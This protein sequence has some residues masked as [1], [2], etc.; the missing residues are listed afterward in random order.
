MEV[1]ESTIDIAASPQT[2]WS[3]IDDIDRYPEWNP[4]VPRIAGRTT[5]GE[6][7]SG[8]LVIPDMPTP[9]LTPMI[10]RIVAGRE[11]RWKSVI[12]GAQGFS[13]EH[14]FILEP[15]GEGT[16]LI[17]REVFDGPAAS[18]LA[19]PIRLFVAPAYRNFDVQLKARAEE[20]AHASPALHPSVAAP[21]AETASH[22]TLRCLC[23]S[24]QVEVTLKEAVQHNHLCGCSK[25]W[26]PQGALL[27]QTAVVAADAAYISAHGEK[28]RLV[29]AASAI[30][31]HSCRDCGT[32]LIGTVEDPTHHFYGLAFVHPELSA[33]R[34]AGKPEFAG[35]ISSVI[36][37]GT[38]A[39][40]MEAIRRE[41]AAAGIE[42]HDAFSPEIMDIIA[43]HRVKVATH[44]S[45]ALAGE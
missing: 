9:P 29:D 28:L 37:S 14:I 24:N 13:A 34:I 20:L 6:R 21:D 17:H 39:S 30:R 2:V 27:A 44:P 7:L 23:A 25:C 43:Y 12:P 18:H 35:F 33:T 42:C 4:I 15:K 19:E 41:L 32:H 40:A 38:S 1:T 31:R 36:E 22:A 26:K 10:T 5:V 16:K 45:L 3:V 8:E 11:F